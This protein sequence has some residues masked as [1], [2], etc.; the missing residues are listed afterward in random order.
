L[1]PATCEAGPSYDAESLLARPDVRAWLPDEPSYPGA[2]SNA[3]VLRDASGAHVV[4]AL[5]WE[6]P[7]RGALLLFS[8]D[9]RLL[10]VEATFGIDALDVVPLDPPLPAL[11]R[12]R[13]RVGGTTSYR[14]KGIDLYVVRDSTLQLAWSDPRPVIYD[15]ERWRGDSAVIYIEREGRIIRAVYKHPCPYLCFRE[16]PDRNERFDWDA[17]T[18]SFRRT[19]GV[20][21]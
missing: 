4:V 9:G 3:V 11:A 16:L 10:D 2:R 19:S 6:G 20:R 18:I 15:G 21:E 1:S 14:N 8:C 5:G 17:K 7:P 12:L 13:Y